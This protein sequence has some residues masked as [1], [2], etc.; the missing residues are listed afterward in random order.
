MCCWPAAEYYCIKRKLNHRQKEDLMSM[1]LA[2]S[3]DTLHLN[4]AD[5]QTRHATPD[6]TE[7][8]TGEV[9]TTESSQRHCQH[10]RRAAVAPV[11]RLRV[12]LQSE[13]AIMSTTSGNFVRS[14]FS[15]CTTYFPSDPPTAW[16]CI[17]RW[18]SCLRWPEIISLTARIWFYN[19]KNP[20]RPAHFVQNWTLKKSWT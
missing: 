12:H 18:K 19:C 15:H 7:H 10:D 6:A 16:R 14:F 9:D 4:V 13:T 17:W 20:F 5:A 2:T 11:L 3:A 8:Q 1:Y